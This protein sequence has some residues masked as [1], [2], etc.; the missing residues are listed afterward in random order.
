MHRGGAPVSCCPCWSLLC[1]SLLECSVGGVLVAEELLLL[2]LL[3]LR[4]RLGD[5]V[6]GCAG[7]SPLRSHLRNCLLSLLFSLSPLH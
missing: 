6:L 5:G 4:L 3:L 1:A 7:A 2:L